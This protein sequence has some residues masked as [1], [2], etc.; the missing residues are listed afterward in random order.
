MD[1]MGNK[2]CKYGN[3]K[4]II[5]EKNMEEAFQVKVCIKDFEFKGKR[6]NTVIPV[7]RI[8]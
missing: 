3:T 7:E 1:D 8:N 5:S 4:E 6:I 2:V